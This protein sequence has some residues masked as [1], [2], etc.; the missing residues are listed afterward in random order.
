M[1]L[2][3]SAARRSPAAR[4]TRSRLWAITGSITFSSKLPDCPPMVI[5]DVVADDLGGTIA[6]ASGI[7]G[8]I[9]PGMMRGARLQGRQGDLASPAW[10][11]LFIQ[12]RSLAIFMRP[13][14][15]VFSWPLTA[16]RR[17][18]GRPGPRS[19]CPPRGNGM[20][21]SRGEARRRRVAPNSGW[22]L[23]P[24]PTAVPPMASSAE[25]R[26][27]PRSMRAAAALDLGR[28]AAELLARGAPAWRPSGGCGRS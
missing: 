9:L 24:V 20:A 4:S 2:S 15:M 16:R 17:R 19:G 21:G 13:A 27:A 10:G 14:A 5:G 22:V 1:A 25:A 8:L 6:T 7:T 12:R 11:P 3:A 23:M 26:A 18:P 28:P